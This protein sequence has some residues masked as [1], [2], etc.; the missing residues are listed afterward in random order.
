LGSLDPLKSL[1]GVRGRLK[2][3]G[4]RTGPDT[5]EMDEDTAAA[6]AEFCGDQK[7]AVP[8]DPL[9]SGFLNRLAKAHGF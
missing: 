4:Y 5:P 6:I 9:D 3:L 8:D 7:I 2:N 1:G